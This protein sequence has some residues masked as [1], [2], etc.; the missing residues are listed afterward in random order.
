MKSIFLLLSVF[1]GLSLSVG[2]HSDDGG[3]IKRDLNNNYSNKETVETV[4]KYWTEKRMREAKPLPLPSVSEDELKQIIKNSKL[5]EKHPPKI[6]SESNASAKNNRKGLEPGVPVNADVSER[7]FWNAGKLYFT[8]PD[9]DHYCSAQFI[10]KSKLLLSAAH[11]VR[12]GTTAEWYKNFMFRQAYENGDSDKDFDIV[13]EAAYAAWATTSGGDHSLDY[14]F[15]VTNKESTAGWM[16]VETDIPYT[17]L[18]AIGYPSNY[19]NGKYLQQVLGEKGTV[20]GGIVQMKNNPMRSGN[21]GGAW[22]AELT[23]DQA[24]GNIAVGLNSFHTSDDTSEYG[25]YFDDTFWSLLQM[26]IAD[27]GL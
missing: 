6:I 17:S 15:L 24:S 13:Y 22:I 26:T 25:P 2:A 3:S 16:G 5:V 14:S 7:P 20:S 1:L 12:D 18:V 27:N 19:G 10:G 4:R 8:A 23:T 9:G 21:S 11:C